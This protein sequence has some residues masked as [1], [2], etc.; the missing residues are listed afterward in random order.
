MIRYRLKF[1]KSWVKSLMEDFFRYDMYITEG[2]PK[3]LGTK[4]RKK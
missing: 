4:V 3:T 2:Y 1:I